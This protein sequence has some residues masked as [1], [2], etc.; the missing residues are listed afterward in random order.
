[1]RCVPVGRGALL[2][3]AGLTAAG[4]LPDLGSLTP[5]GMTEPQGTVLTPLK[6]KSWRSPKPPEAPGSSSSGAWMGER[7]GSTP[8]QLIWP[9]L[10]PG[11]IVGRL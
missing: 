5:E 8:K 7:V 1:M 3:R 2:R 6:G 9:L 4:V 10:E 11:D